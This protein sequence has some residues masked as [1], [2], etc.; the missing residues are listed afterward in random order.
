MADDRYR[1]TTRPFDVR[2]GK[3]NRTR[4]TASANSRRFASGSLAGLRCF[5]MTAGKCR[6]SGIP[7]SAQSGASFE[8]DKEAPVIFGHGGDH[9]GDDRFPRG[10][11]VRERD[12]LLRHAGKAPFEL[13]TVR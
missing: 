7:R 4:S 2:C 11:K 6:A 3:G 9:R 10:F 8:A 13:F 1:Q 12:R 5:R